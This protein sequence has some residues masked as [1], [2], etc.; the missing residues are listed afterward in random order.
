MT[1]EVAHGKLDTKNQAKFRMTAVSLRYKHDG[2]NPMLYPFAA[3]IRPI[4]ATRSKSNSGVIDQGSPAQTETLRKRSHNGLIKR[5][6]FASAPPPSGGGRKTQNRSLMVSRAPR[7][8]PG[9][10]IRDRRLTFPPDLGRCAAGG[11]E[12][13]HAAQCSNK[14]STSIRRT[15]PTICPNCW[16]RERSGW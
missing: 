15:A 4:N 2:T 9:S 10:P 16:P 13:W 12:L 3:A 6:L 8:R 11:A 7:D 14:S 5:S 1:Q